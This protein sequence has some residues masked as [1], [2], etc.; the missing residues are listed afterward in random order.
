MFVS[1]ELFKVKKYPKTRIILKIF[2]GQ[3]NLRS[4]KLEKIMEKVMESHGM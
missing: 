2:Q 3:L 4:G 1:V